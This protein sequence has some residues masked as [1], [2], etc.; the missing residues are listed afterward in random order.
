MSLTP[1][2]MELARLRAR[3]AT[4]SDAHKLLKD[5]QDE[6]VRRFI[7][8]LRET[9][10]LHEEVDRALEALSLQAGLSVAGLPNQL[11]QNMSLV[12]ETLISTQIKRR[13]WMGVPLVEVSYTLADAKPSSAMVSNPLLSKSESDLRQLL[14]KILQLTA[15]E[16]NCQI[17]AREIEALRRR[18]NA[19]EHL[20]IPDLRRKM[21]IIRMKL[22]ESE[23]D[24]ITR[25]IKI[26][27][28][29]E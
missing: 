19:L 15:A 14:P 18:V 8:L 1:T 26:K 11:I 17:L 25:L 9:D 21:R 27:S 3:L 12:R 22:A 7:T 29:Q 10:S 4:S 5:K 6:L 28:R 16:K 23:R 2:R 13:N 24:T 20:V